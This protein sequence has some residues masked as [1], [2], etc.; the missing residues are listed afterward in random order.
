MSP[1]K[2]GA[3]A[4]W[5]WISAGVFAVTGI[6]FRRRPGEEVA[7]SWRLAGGNWAGLL[8]SGGHTCSPCCPLDS[9]LCVCHL[10]KTT[11]NLQ[12]KLTRISLRGPEGL[13]LS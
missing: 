8:R 10:A 6:A 2:S 1:G 5:L 3:E 11:F 9:A 12:S 13:L 7:L 4:L